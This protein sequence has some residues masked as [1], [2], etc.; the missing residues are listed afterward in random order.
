VTAVD[1]GGIAV[2]DMDT[3]IAFYRDTFGM[4]T[5][6]TEVNE[7]QG[8]HEAMVRTRGDDGSGTAVQLL[9]PSRPESTIAKFL[10]TKGPGL[11]Q[12][13]YSVRDIDAMTEA[14]RRRG[15]GCSTRRPST[16]PRTAAST[17]CIPRTR[18]AC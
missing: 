17:S 2:P 11:Q 15:C 4:K 1:H 13:A 8:V 6:H 16:A 3:A 5:V 9:A 12:V 10:D 18:A 7:E 14:S